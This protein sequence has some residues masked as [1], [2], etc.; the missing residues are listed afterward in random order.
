MVSDFMAFCFRLCSFRIGL[1]NNFPELC[2]VR[3]ENSRSCRILCLSYCDLSCLQRVSYS[4]LGA[5]IALWDAY[6]VLACRLRRKAGHKSAR[7]MSLSRRGLRDEEKTRTDSRNGYVPIVLIRR[8]LPPPDQHDRTPWNPAPIGLFCFF[9]LHMFFR[10]SV[11]QGKRHCAS[12]ALG[13]V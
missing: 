6:C 12:P 11:P 7:C 5:F 10:L 3:P 2:S 4:E 13:C 9:V 8:G 1:I